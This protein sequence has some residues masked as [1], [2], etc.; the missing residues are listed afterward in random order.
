MYEGRLAALSS[1]GRGYFHTKVVG[2]R[3]VGRG[4]A[5]G[6]QKAKNFP[7]TKSKLPPDRE[8]CGILVKK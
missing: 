7:L 5:Q 4:L 2:V 8:K 1:R 3:R 6:G